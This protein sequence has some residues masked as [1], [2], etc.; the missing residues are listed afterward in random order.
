[1]FRISL[2][3]GGLSPSCTPSG[4]QSVPV[5][6]LSSFSISFSVRHVEAPGERNRVLHFYYKCSSV[7]G[8]I[9]LVVQRTEL[10]VQEQQKL[11]TAMNWLCHRCQVFKVITQLV[12][13]KVVAGVSTVPCILS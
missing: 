12:W 3:V 6:S 1:M 11:K 7:S 10:H 4:Y 8:T 13:Q 5:T 9:L 2:S